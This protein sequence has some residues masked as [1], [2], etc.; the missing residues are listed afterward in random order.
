MS[1]DD[2]TNR[3]PNNDD[4]E[5]PASV[6]FTEMM[7]RAANQS[8]EP[9]EATPPVVP[10]QPAPPVEP[11]PPARTEEELR[12]EA[13][14]EAQR[15]RRVERR[16]ETAR[17]RTASAFGGTV[18]TL[19]V[20]FM[21][22]ALTATILSWWTSPNALDPEVR[23]SISVASA[24]ESD[25]QALPTAASTPPW[26]QRIGIVSGHRGPENDPG[27]VCYE[28]GEPV[29][30]ENEIN[31]AIS[32]LVVQGLRERRYNVELLDEFDVRLENYEATALIS[33]HANDC[34]TY[35]GELPSGYLVSHA[36][37]RAEGGEDTRLRECV[38][39]YYERVAQIDR[40]FGLTRDMTDYHIFREIHPNTP[41][42]ILETGF[43]LAD[44]DLLVNEADRLAQGIV[45]G[46]ECF[47]KG[48]ALPAVAPTPPPD[49]QNG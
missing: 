33:I 15:V 30:T 41:G 36:E 26:L 45:R 4:H 22:A 35:Q 46:I 5:M 3:P 40:R 37:A 31:L 38:A 29:L 12:R 44:Q 48:E 24:T 17:Q 9:P 34:G 39:Y 13:A 32:L 8:P 47:I 2:N 19:I 6:I 49:T 18:L 14:L 25:I 43:M 27:A 11:Q 16:K 23:A 28:N 10:Q 21:A 1:R 42:I 20:P 7:R